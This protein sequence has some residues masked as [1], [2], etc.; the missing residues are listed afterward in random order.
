MLIDARKLEPGS[1]V[2]ADICIVGAGAAGITLARELAGTRRKVAVLE[3]GGLEFEQATQDLYAGEVV[4]RAFPID[5]DRLR[6]FGGTTNH[7]EGGCRPFDP[8]DFK[9]RAHV[10]HSGWP[11]GIEEMEPYYRRAQEICQLGPFTYD[12]AAWTAGGPGPLDFGAD[13]RIDTVVFQNSPPTRFGEVYRADLEKAESIAVYLH[14]NVVDIETTDN[15]RE[16]TRL[17]VACL[18]GPRFSVKATRYVLAT[19]GIENPRLLLNCDKVETTGLGNQHDLV[20]RFFMDHPNLRKTANIVFNE[21]Y[22]NFAFYDYH[23]VNGIKIYAGFS[24][25]EEVQA[26]EGLPNFYILIDPGHLADESTSVASLRSLYKSARAGHWPDHLGFHLGRIVG[27]LDGLAAA[28]YRRATGRA[29]PLFST[30]Y[31]CEVPPDPESRVSL[32]SATDALGLRRV[33]LDWRLPGDFEATMHRAHLLLGAELGRAGLG[34]LRLNTAETT[35]DP[36]A[37]IENGHHHMGTTRMHEDPKQGVV[38]ANC[39]VHGKANLYVAGSSV[40]PTYSFDNPTMTLV[41]LAARLAD[42]LKSQSVDE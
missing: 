7:W 41:A 18:D 14:A 26:R 2:E 23:V 37:D 8:L 9:K 20:G 6:F 29:A 40:F 12:P 39:R 19:G 33:R 36:M 31:S 15:A 3:S 22:P 4:G 27:D 21:A 24:A 35:A 25:S 10:P 16:V 1:T 42:H 34:R 17:G 32:A 38:D 5:S 13:A 11:F 28:L 30:F